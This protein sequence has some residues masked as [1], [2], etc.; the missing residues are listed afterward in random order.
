MTHLPF[1]IVGFSL[2]LLVPAAKAVMLVDPFTDGQLIGGADN[3]GIAWYDRSA[4]TVAEIVDD[5]T[6]F[7]SGNAL[8]LRITNT[9]QINRPVLGVFSPIT[10]AVGETLTLSFDFR[11]EL[12]PNATFNNTI[13][14]FRF[15][16]YNSNGTV[17]TAD[18]STQ[19]DNDFGYQARASA[20]GPPRVSDST[21][22]SATG[23]PANSVPEPIV[24][25]SIRM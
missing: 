7:G 9:T 15:G 12:T 23:S 24:S 2:G 11:F 10:L 3:S 14:G 18:G 5:S 8:R 16:F 21:E 6:G 1:A 25:R 13:D 20:P 4:N 22:K 17:V 19:S